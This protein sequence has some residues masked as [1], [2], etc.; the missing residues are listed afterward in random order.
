MEGLNYVNNIVWSNNAFNIFQNA[1]AG[2][3][4]LRPESRYKFAGSDRRDIGV[5]M[6]TLEPA[7]NYYYRV[8]CASDQPSSRFRTL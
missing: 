1:P 6:D 3:F 7:T 5:D 2:N 4:R 8:L